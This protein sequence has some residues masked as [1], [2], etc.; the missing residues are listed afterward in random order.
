[1]NFD[2]LNVYNYEKEFLNNIDADKSLSHFDKIYP[3]I[4]KEI[5]NMSEK[6]KIL[7][8][9]DN[10]DQALNA[11]RYIGLVMP[12]DQTHIDLFHVDVEEPE[13]F[14]DSKTNPGFEVPQISMWK[15]HHQKI[16]DIFMKQAKEILIDAGFNDDAICIHVRP[17]HNGVT[18][19]IIAES[20]K[21]YHAVVVG[22]N[23]NSKMK[24]LLMGST[25]S[26][27]IGK[28]DHL[29]LLI[30]GGVPVSKKILIAFDGSECAME[31][32]KKVCAIVNPLNTEIFLYHVI[33]SMELFSPENN[34]FN[35]P[36]FEKKWLQRGQSEIEPDLNKA[37]E[38]ILD[39][40]F[41]KGNVHKEVGLGHMSRAD[42]IVEKAKLERCDTIIVGRR[43]LSFVQEFFIGRVGQKVLHL[44]DKMTVWVIN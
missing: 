13:I 28:I 30:V 38:Y 25:A 9:M 22:R 35:D 6:H 33:R 21:G 43:G 11:A 2:C 7:L 24:D 8:A 41:S 34:I 15:A 31:A 4:C 27:L 32:V 42:A 12:L 29:P 19:D 18:R 44:A 26:R 37:Y 1:M 36:E 40:G 5:K 16:I 3:I 39:A 20:T 14:W 10:S 17:R 23:G